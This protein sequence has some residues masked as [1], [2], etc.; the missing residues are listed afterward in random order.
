MIRSR[1]GSCHALLRSHPLLSWLYA[2]TSSM[3]TPDRKTTA[4]H[5][6]GAMN[7]H[8]LSAGHDIDYLT[9]LGMAGTNNHHAGAVFRLVNTLDAASYRSALTE[10][11]RL[12]RK[13]NAANR[14]NMKPNAQNDLAKTSLDYFICPL[15]PACKGRKYTL[16]HGTPNL[17]PIIC[18]HCGG[19]GINKP[20]TKRVSAVAHEIERSVGRLIGSVKGRIR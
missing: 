1:H 5:L 20:K 8:D 17:S 15:C 6:A 19:T 9:A 12:V 16:I 10:T 4:D 14:W 3:T 11:I 13:L 7:S 2:D 18:K